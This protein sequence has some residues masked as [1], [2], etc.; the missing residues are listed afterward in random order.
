[1]G[2]NAGLTRLR[3]SLFRNLTTQKGHS[4]NYVR[5]LLVHSDGSEWIGTTDG[6]NHRVADKIAPV[7]FSPALQVPS[8]RSLAEGPDGDVRVGTY[9]DGV[10]RLRQGKEIARYG[11]AQ[12]LGSNSMMSI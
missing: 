3:V 1:M 9:V 12:G 4:D 5:T 10:I 2:T 11:R 7:I 8:F 6:L